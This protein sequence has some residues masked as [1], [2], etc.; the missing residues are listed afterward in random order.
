MVKA[1]TGL[2]LLA[3]AALLLSLLTVT[4]VAADTT[5]VVLLPPSEGE[6]GAEAGSFPLTQALESVIRLGVERV[7]EDAVLLDDKEV[8]LFTHTSTGVP[9][10]A[11]LCESIGRNDTIVAVSKGSVYLCS[12]GA[13]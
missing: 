9:A 5:L 1:M 6:E 2:L 8:T 13:G 10:A 3:A 7:N 4:E 11:A 12:G